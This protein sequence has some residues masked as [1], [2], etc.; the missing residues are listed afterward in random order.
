MD[1]GDPQSYPTVM[2]LIVAK[3]LEQ[4]AGYLGQTESLLVL[5]EQRD[6]WLTVD[7]H[8]ADLL[9]EQEGRRNV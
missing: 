4:G 9:R 7:V 1:A 2:D 5:H 6:D 8:G 3:I